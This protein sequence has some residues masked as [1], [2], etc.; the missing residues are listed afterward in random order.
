MRRLS[1]LAITAVLVL[2][3]TACGASDLIKGFRVGFSASKPAIQSLVPATISQAKADTV[4]RDVD[5]GITAAERGEQCIKAIVE[6]GPQKRVEQARCYVELAN[7]LRV[8]LARH[9]IGGSPILNQI[10]SLVQAA[11][12]AFEEFNR[13]V[14]PSGRSASLPNEAVAKA[15]EQKLKDKLKVIERDLKALTP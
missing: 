13:S 2:A 10:A 5:A 4:V 15:A 8:I 11:I 3:I 7:D 9:N 12:S 14:T 6:T 1:K